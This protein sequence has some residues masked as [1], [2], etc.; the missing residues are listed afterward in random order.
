MCLLGALHE[1]PGTGETGET[2]AATE[3]REEIQLK[4]IFQLGFYALL[5]EELK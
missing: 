1:C 3:S 2:D 5:P 4:V